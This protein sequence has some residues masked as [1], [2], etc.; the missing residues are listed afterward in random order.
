MDN[1]LG[2]QVQKGPVTP[3]PVAGHIYPAST[4]FQC[5]ANVGTN[6]TKTYVNEGILCTFVWW[7]L[8]KARRHTIKSP[9]TKI[10]TGK[11]ILPDGSEFICGWP[12][13]RRPPI[14]AETD[15]QT[16]E[17]AARS[18]AEQVGVPPENSSFCS[19]VVCRFFVWF[20]SCLT[21]RGTSKSIRVCQITI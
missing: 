17:E 3:K 9:L 8:C 12:P 20:P 2:E 18:W 7:L 5:L 11:E 21:P 6:F 13:D 15:R 10:K 19:T 1:L 16:V 14:M 4:I